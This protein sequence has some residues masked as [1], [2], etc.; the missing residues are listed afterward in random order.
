MLQISLS[1]SNI[2]DLTIAVMIYSIF[3]FSL[4]NSIKGKYKLDLLCY[5]TQISLLL[6]DLILYE[7]EPKKLEKLSII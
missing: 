5:P 2:Y 4:I 6:Y 1:K 3:T 7:L